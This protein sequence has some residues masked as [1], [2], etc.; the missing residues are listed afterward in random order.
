[1][2]AAIARGARIQ[3]FAS[4]A[5]WFHDAVTVAPFYGGAHGMARRLARAARAVERFG[6]TGEVDM[7]PAYQKGN[8]NAAMFLD[9]DYYAN[10]ARGAIAA[11][12]NQMA[13]MS[14]QHWLLFDGLRSARAL[15]VPTLF[16]HSDGCVF[17]DNVR[18]I[19]AAL[20]GPKTLVWTDGFQVD[21]YDQRHLVEPAVAAAATH[22]DATLR[23][24]ADT[25]GMR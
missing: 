3:S 2:A 6:A 15:S 18:R 25:G 22:F 16:V 5:G 4:V 21:F 9:L 7:V 12:T 17:P 1:V 13:T 20:G 14:W 8:E 24:R 23:K 10:P 19:C 11:W